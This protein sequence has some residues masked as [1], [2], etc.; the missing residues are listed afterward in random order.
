[1][2]QISNVSLKARFSIVLEEVK[3]GQ[4]FAIQCEGSQRTIALLAPPPN[5]VPSLRRL[6]VLKGKAR[7]RLR[8]GFKMTQEE[9]LE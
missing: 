2:K 4:T 8:A 9:F 3:R 1:M 5:H 7:F 6:G